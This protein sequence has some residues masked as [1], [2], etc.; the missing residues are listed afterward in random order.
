MHARMAIDSR[1][2]SFVTALL[3]AVC[4]AA[5]APPDAVEVQ[6]HYASIR[7]DQAF[8]RQGPSY[9]HRILWIYKRKDY[10]VKILASFDAWRRVRDVDGSVGWM[11]RSQLSDRRSVLFI[12][13]TKSP[14]HAD[15]DPK[16]KIVA[17]AAPGVVAWLKACEMSACDVE[18]SGAEGWVDKRNIW[19]VDAGEVFQ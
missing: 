7:R 2:P 5:A 14:L 1:F 11:H 3:V 4:A 19:G 13:F 18:V 9:A 17:Y 10:P 15:S 8:L 12:G 16:A 6:P